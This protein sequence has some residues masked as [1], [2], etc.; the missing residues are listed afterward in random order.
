MLVCTDV[1]NDTS[2]LSTTITSLVS[3]SITVIISSLMCVQPALTSYKV[4]N[5]EMYDFVHSPH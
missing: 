1:V 5:Y 4:I 3:I 2:L